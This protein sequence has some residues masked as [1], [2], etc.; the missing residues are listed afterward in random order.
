MGESLRKARAMETRLTLS[1][2]ERDSG[3]AD[4]RVEAVGHPV[5]DLV[6]AGQTDRLAQ[7]VVSGLRVAETDVGLDRVI[8][9]V[10]VLLDHREL[11]HH[12]LYRQQPGIDTAN[13][14]SACVGVEEPGG[15][16]Q[17]RALARS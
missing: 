15:Q 9:Q 5:D 7:F 17:D 13:A 11:L 16:L 8:E 6:D 14:H 3:L 1:A 2:R 12:G 10:D 4:L